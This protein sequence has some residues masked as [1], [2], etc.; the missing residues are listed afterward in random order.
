MSDVAFF[1]YIFAYPFKTT[2]RMTAISA[3]NNHKFGKLVTGGYCCA[4][5]EQQG[6]KSIME[7]K[8]LRK[9]RI[10]ARFCEL[11]INFV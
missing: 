5:V 7:S 1:T 10:Y 3:A 4:R 8:P 9:V 11:V 2:A 6:E